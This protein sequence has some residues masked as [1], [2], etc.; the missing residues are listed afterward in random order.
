MRPVAKQTLVSRLKLFVFW[1]SD[2]ASGDFLLSECGKRQIAFTEW[3][4]YQGLR[5]AAW[6]QSHVS[7]ARTGVGNRSVGQNREFRDSG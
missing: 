4:L 5:Q 3:S 7:D 1:D 6:Q 2:S